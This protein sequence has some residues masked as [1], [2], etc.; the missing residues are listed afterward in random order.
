[1][2]EGR[3]AVRAALVEFGEPALDALELALAEPNTSEAL[4][5]QLP[6]ALARFR[7]QRAGDIL[8]RQLGNPLHSGLMRYRLLRALGRMVAETRVKIARE[9]IDANIQQNLLEYLRV[10]SL[11]VALGREPE[12]PHAERSLRLVRGLLEAKL[13]QSLERAFLLLQIRHRNENI[14]RV[15]FALRSPDRRLRAYAL[16]FL[17]TLTATRSRSAMAEQLRELLLIVAD[18]L[19]PAERVLRAARFVPDR[20]QSHAQAL[21]LLLAEK[22]EYVASFAAYHALAL[23]SLELKQEVVAAVRRRPQLDRIG[24][25]A[26]LFPASLRVQH[27]S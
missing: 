12:F 17:D 10:L 5:L 11:D 3:A 15:Q 8:A 9:P 23:G 7:G 13:E 1:M 25:T 2:H 14:R 18:D 27:E 20:P 6:R 21:R 4:R 16:E 22:D 19:P 26:W 24:E